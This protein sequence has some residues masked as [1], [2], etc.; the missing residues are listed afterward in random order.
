MIKILLAS[1]Y[2]VTALRITAYINCKL[3]GTRLCYIMDDEGDW[4]PT[5]EKHIQEQVSLN[6]WEPSFVIRGGAQAAIKYYYR[7]LMKS[8]DMRGVIESNEVLLN[9]LVQERYGDDYRK[10]ILIEFNRNK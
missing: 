7:R 1:F 8:L 6:K 3:D 5:T 4:V 9:E 2:D 10:R